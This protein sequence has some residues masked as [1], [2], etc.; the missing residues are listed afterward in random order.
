MT[1]MLS[2][3]ILPAVLLTI[4]ALAQTGTAAAPPSPAAASTAARIGIINIQNAIVT[5]NEGRRDLEALQKKFEPTQ[6]ALNNLNQ[7]IENLK[8]QLQTQSD[9][10][11]E[12]A[13]A[14]MVKNIETKQKTLQRQ[15]E[16]AQADFQGQQNDIANRIGGKLLEVLDK[17]A[18]QNG[19]SVIIDVSSQQSPVLW[20]A[21]N[22]DVTQEIVSAYNTQSGVPA[23]AAAAPPAKPVGGTAAR[24]PAPKPP[25]PKR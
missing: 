15:V 24:P 17:F 5:T 6:A 22:T 14:D 12:Q 16:D 8:K 18:K 13:R 2:R 3:F 21:A 7:E 4:T 9:K 11:N 23:P 20:A 19:Y 25:A 1:R 10:L